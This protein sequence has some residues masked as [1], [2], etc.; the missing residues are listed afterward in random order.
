MIIVMVRFEKSSGGG[1]GIGIQIHAKKEK[2]ASELSSQFEGTFR[3]K[4]FEL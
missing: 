2:Y 1:G 4:D 3:L